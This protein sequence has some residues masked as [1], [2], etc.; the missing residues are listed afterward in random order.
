MRKHMKI[1]PQWIL[2][3]LAGLSF[4]L[5]LAMIAAKWG[6]NFYKVLL[7]IFVL[8]GLVMFARYCRRMPLATITGLVLAAGCFAGFIFFDFFL[9][10]PAVSWEGLDS[11]PMTLGQFKWM[12]FAVLV[13]S[14]VFRGKTK[15]LLSAAT[16]PFCIF[17]YGVCAV[18]SGMVA[19][20]LW[21]FICFPL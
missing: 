1:K 5:V 16:L 19:R 17:F 8:L 4:F 15:D 10:L 12:M 21:N 13:L 11:I 2:L 18:I 20:L 9:R 14:L 3:L 7:V 6:L